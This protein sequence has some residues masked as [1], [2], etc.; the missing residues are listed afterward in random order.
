MAIPLWAGELTVDGNLVVKTNLVVQGQ[1]SGATLALTNLTITGQA[2]IQ[3]AV[4]QALPPQGD[5]SMGPYTNQA[6]Q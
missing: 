3:S 1:L 6:A 2:R 4:I 5:L